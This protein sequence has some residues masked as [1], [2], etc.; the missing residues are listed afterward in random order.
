MFR[1][2]GTL[3][4]L[5]PVRD[6]A[7]PAFDFQKCLVNIQAL[8]MDPELHVGKCKVCDPNCFDQCSMYFFKKTNST[9]AWWYTPVAPVA[10][11]AEAGGLFE[12]RSSRPAWATYT[13]F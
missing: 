10:Q 13:H 11:E 9:W 8:L 7:F 4:I 2:P 3:E 12:A 6:T 5:T 1:N